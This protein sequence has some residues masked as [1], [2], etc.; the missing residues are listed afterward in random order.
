MEYLR[1]V[2]ASVFLP[3]PEVDSAF[4]RLL[5]REPGEL[6]SCNSLAFA[7][8]VRKGFSQRRKQL[9]KLLRADVPDWDAAAATC[10]FEPRAR[11][12][13]L[14]L[15]Q[16]IALSNLA[17]RAALDTH[18][19]PPDERFPVVDEEDRVIGEAPRA[20][21]H[22]NNLRHRAVHILIFND[23]GEL[24]LQKRSEWK[25]RHPRVWDSSAAGHVDAGEDYDVAAQRELQEE[26]GV[27]AALERVVR[28]PASEATGQ[29]FI[30]VYQ[31]RHNGPFHLAAAEIEFGAFYPTA[32]V[33]K[34][35]KARPAEFAPGFIECWR[36]YRERQPLTL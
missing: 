34:W 10:A 16:W 21:V 26:L 14:S 2:P 5:P 23:R 33:A 3:T 20:E 32:I 1:T 17:D 11:A 6:P 15:Q 25:D 13:E 28:L 27:T 29:E 22:G 31:A 4:V 35:I 7:S 36:A 18:P 9:Q 12:E 30:W 8:L 19:S 24:F